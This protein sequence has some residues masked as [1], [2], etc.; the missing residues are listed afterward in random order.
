LFGGVLETRI[1]DSLEGQIGGGSDDGSAAAQRGGVGNAQIVAESDFGG[2]W[3][4]KK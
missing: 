2:I 3:R 4:P 1:V